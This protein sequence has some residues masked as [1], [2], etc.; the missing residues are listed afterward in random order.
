MFGA[1]STVQ[2]DRVGM[3]EK[4]HDDLPTISP[5]GLFLNHRL[6]SLALFGALSGEKMPV[7]LAYSGD[8]LDKSN[9]DRTPSRHSLIFDGGDMGVSQGKLLRC[10]LMALT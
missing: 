10:Q 5:S 3:G 8:S 6:T 4:E 2:V 1:V 9:D 7:L